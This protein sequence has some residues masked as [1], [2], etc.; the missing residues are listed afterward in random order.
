MAV[1]RGA[2]AFWLSKPSR[3]QHNLGCSDGAIG[4]WA[5]AGAEGAKHLVSPCG[6]ATPVLGRKMDPALE[7]NAG[8]MGS[9]AQAWRARPERSG[10][11]SSMGIGNC[12]EDG[13]P[14]G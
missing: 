9:R 6:E 12:E 11:A 14:A 2:V 13:D 4:T 10:G 5:V 3:R 8:A 7:G 1:T